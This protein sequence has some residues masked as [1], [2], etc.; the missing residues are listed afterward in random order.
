[1][2]KT[3]VYINYFTKN[4]FILSFD[5]NYVPNEFAKILV[6]VVKDSKTASAM[7]TELI[8]KY[9][10]KL[11][12]N[13]LYDNEGYVYQIDLYY[14]KILVNKNNAYL[15]GG[16]WYNFDTWA[17]HHDQ[18]DLA[19]AVGKVI[20]FTYKGGSGTGKRLI[21]LKS[22]FGSGNGTILK[23]WDIEKSTG[24]KPAY[25]SYKLGNIVGDIEVIG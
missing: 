20:R 17:K 1:M 5:K 15:Y 8:S 22:V 19:N 7:A 12:D 10:A 3:A 6:K 4:K 16:Y 23:G 13:P 21:K 18:Q 14:S 2:V 25:R 24:D 11:E 9:G